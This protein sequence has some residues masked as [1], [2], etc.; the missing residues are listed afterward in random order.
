MLTVMVVLPLTAPLV[1][2]TVAPPAV[3]PAV[4]RP[5]ESTDPPPLVTDQVKL[6]CEAIASPNWSFAD[7]ANC[8]WPFSESVGVPGVTTMLVSVWL[9]VMLTSLVTDAVPSEIVARRV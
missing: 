6:G 2:V 9:T 7:A 8:C 4:Y 3:A 5:E 1:A